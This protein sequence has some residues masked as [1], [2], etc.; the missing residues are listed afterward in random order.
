MN[1]FVV[2]T[3]QFALWYWIGTFNCVGPL[4]ATPTETPIASAANATPTR[5]NVR[6]P[7]VN[8]IIQKPPSL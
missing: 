2:R 5:T 4:F 6:R 7:R 1:F 3:P 8:R